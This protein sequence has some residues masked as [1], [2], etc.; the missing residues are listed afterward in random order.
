MKILLTNTPWY[1]VGYYGVRAGARWPHLIKLPE[2]SEKQRPFVPFPFFLSYGAAVLKSKG[3]E[4]FVIDAIADGLDEVEFLAR[5]MEISPQVV[6]QEVSTPTIVVDLYYAERIKKICED[7][8]IIFCG[9]NHLMQRERFLDANKVVDIVIYGEYEYT[10]RNIIKEM[11]H[12]EPTFK[13]INGIIYRDSGRVIKNLPAPL[14]ENLDSLP[15]PARELFPMEKYQNASMGLPHPRLQIWTSRGCPYI[16]N[17]CLWPQLM[18]G[19][20]NYRV[21]KPKDIAEEIAFCVKKWKFKSFYFNDDTF[22]LG[23]E[24]LLELAK[25]IKSHKIGLPFSFSPH[26]DAIDEEHL[27]ALKSAGLHSMKLGIESG[28]QELIDA[29]GKK[30]DLKKVE[31][32]VALARQNGILVHMTFSLGLPGETVKTIQETINYALRLDPNSAHFAIITPAPGSR[33]YQE[34]NEKGY[35]LSKNW[36]DYDGYRRSVIRTDNLKADEIEGALKRARNAWNVQLHIR[37]KEFN[38]DSAK[39]AMSNLTDDNR[40]FILDTSFS[41][42]IHEIIYALPESIDI[43]YLKYVTVENRNKDIEKNFPE[44]EKV[45]LPDNKI[46]PKAI[47][48]QFKNEKDIFF[49]LPVSNERGEGIEDIFFLLQKNYPRNFLAI[50]IRGEVIKKMKR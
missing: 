5:V 46:T 9:P 45:I 47:E 49:L 13:M 18:Y 21:R 1:K 3:H 26:A 27:L 31:N 28:S 12:E 29:C 15:W 4:V 40:I 22:N 42:H 10:L 41:E 25:E 44:R 20:A 50:N 48:K 36:E 30:L 32:L 35:I 17:F 39:K 24:D 23:K 2:R 37:N 11:D 16:C 6:V 34:L 33:Y 43:H 38:V 19:G 14:I 7:V 8:K